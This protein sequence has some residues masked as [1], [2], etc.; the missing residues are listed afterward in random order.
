MNRFYISLNISNKK[1]LVY[2]IEF[3]FVMINFHCLT[4]AL[5]YDKYRN[6]IGNF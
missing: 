6:V 5:Q 4:K 1:E 2:E 3:P